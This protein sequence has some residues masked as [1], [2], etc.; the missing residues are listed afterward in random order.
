MERIAW[1][2]RRTFHLRVLM[3]DQAPDPPFDGEPY[4][5]LV[6]AARPTT[7]AQK[8]RIA[9]ALIAS[10][11]RYVV[12]GG[13]ES[14][15]WEDAADHAYLLQDLPEPVPDDRLVMTT[16]H[17]GEPEDEVARFFVH[18]T[19]FGDHVFTRYLVLLVGADDA[20]RA[21]LAAAVREAVDP[22]THV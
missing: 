18:D 17:R 3:P 9:Q 7:D 16:S 4:P 6:W 8:Q 20:V 19:C 22:R 14:E 1:D 15:A 5:A 21:R 11:C 12:C 13:E 10:G 2:A